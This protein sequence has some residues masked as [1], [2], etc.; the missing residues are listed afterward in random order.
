MNTI[1][2]NGKKY[3]FYVHLKDHSPLC[4]GGLW[5]EWHDQQTGKI[6]QSFSIVTTKGNEMLSKIHNKPKLDGPRM[7]VILSVESANEWID[8][9]LSKEAIQKLI[10]PYP[11]ETMDSYTVGSLQGKAS[12]GNAKKILEPVIYNVLNPNHQRKAPELFD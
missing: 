9:C 6:E 8:T 12:K 2:I 7:P 11:D 4:L 5:S 3:L 10:V 1:I